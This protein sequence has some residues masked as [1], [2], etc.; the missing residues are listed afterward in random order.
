MP[1][2]SYVNTT[3][4]AATL[5]ARTDNGG[6]AVADLTAEEAR[7]AG[8]AGYTPGFLTADAFKVAPQSSPNMTVKL[9]SG[10]SKAD[11]YVVS[12]ALAGQGNYVLRLDVTSQNL[13][14]PAADSSQN[15]LDEVYLVVRD[16]AYDSSTLVLPQIGYRR[17]DLG[18]AAP[19]ADSSWRA[20]ALLA[21][22]PVP[23]GATAISA[24]TD[25]RVSAGLA[26]GLVATLRALF[27]TRPGQVSAGD[28]LRGTSGND[29][30]RVPIGAAGQVLRVQ[31]S[32]WGWSDLGV[33]QHRYLVANEANNTT[34]FINVGRDQGYDPVAA[35]AAPFGF[36]VPPGARYIVEAFLVMDSANTGTGA[37]NKLQ[38][39]LGTGLEFMWSL[40]APLYDSTASG[41][42]GVD[43]RAFGTQGIG[44]NT[45]VTIGPGDANT[46]G[47]RIQGSVYNPTGTAAAIGLQYAAE[48]SGQ[49][50]YV[51]RASWLRY[52]RM[53]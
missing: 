48:T 20:S 45:Q 13:T 22:I 12:G 52:T 3:V 30:E 46:D 39:T 4:A 41:S 9:G 1:T 29:V 11:H 31:G 21:Q 10:S 14:V 23:A 37:R 32:T 49:T 40:I 33:P 19:G 44:G 35:A 25:R 53:A 15:R 51:A 43:Y 36:T 8:A 2:T 7:I 34:G 24:V 26:A 28:L 27:V 42:G 16:N 6:A 18:G 50:A 47:V 38:W 17:G 5:G